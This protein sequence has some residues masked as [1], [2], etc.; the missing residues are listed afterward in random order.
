[1]LKAVTVFTAAFRAVAMRPL[2]L[3]ALKLAL[4]ATFIFYEGLG[5]RLFRYFAFEILLLEAFFLCRHVMVKGVG[6]LLLLLHIAHLTNVFSTGLLMETET[7]LNLTQYSS[8]SSATL[9]KLFLFL[10]FCLLIWTP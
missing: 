7:L 9:L 8:L 10:I 1:M 2:F 4:L 5:S 3:A 6:V